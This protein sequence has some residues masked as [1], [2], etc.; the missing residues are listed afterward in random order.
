MIAPIITQPKFP[1][2]YEK[3]ETSK[4][5][6]MKIYVSAWNQTSDPSLSN[7]VP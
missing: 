1:S 5:L 3:W 4:N 2:S 6:K 7:W